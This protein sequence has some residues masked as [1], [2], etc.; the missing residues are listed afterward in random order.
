MLAK[1]LLPRALLL[2][3]PATADTLKGKSYIIELSSSQY[4]SGYGEYLVQLLERG[5]NG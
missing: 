4:A 1:P 5:P 2:A 3:A